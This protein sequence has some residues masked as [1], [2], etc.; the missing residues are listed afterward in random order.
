MQLL[1]KLSNKK[2]RQ[3]NKNKQKVCIR[4]T[5][6]KKVIISS[7]SSLNKKQLSVSILA[8]KKSL[9]KTQDIDIAII[10]ANT[11]YA[12]YCLEDVSFFVLLIKDI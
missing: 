10:S 8:I 7:L 6:L 5:S 4:E 1:N 9:P 2:R 11:C 12:A 3:I